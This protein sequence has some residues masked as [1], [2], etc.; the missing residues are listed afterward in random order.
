M[1]QPRDLESFTLT[2][3]DIHRAAGSV[4]EQH[5][6]LQRQYGHI[7]T[8]LEDCGPAPP[9][10]H[11]YLPVFL[12]TVRQE[13]RIA[14]HIKHLS[15]IQQLEDF[16][17]LNDEHDLSLKDALDSLNISRSEYQRDWFEG[18]ERGVKQLAAGLLLQVLPNLE[19]FHWCSGTSPLQLTT[20]LRSRLP[21]R[22]E[23]NRPR[24][25][26]LERFYKI[27]TP[28]AGLNPPLLPALKKVILDVPEVAH[29]TRGNTVLHQII[30][31]LALASIESL[32][33][34]SFN[35][36]APPDERNP[37]IALVP[38]RCS[39][40]REL[41]LSLSSLGEALD[42]LLRLPRSLRRLIFVAPVPA[43]APAPHEIFPLDRLR[44]YDLERLTI[45]MRRWHDHIDREALPRYRKLLF[46]ETSVF[47]TDNATLSPAGWIK[48]YFPTSMQHIVF[49]DEHFETQMDNFLY[50]QQILEL[51][52][53]G[54]L[55]DL[56]RLTLRA[57]RVRLQGFEMEVQ[58]VEQDC[59]AQDVE[60]NV[61]FDWE[62]SIAA[63]PT[64]DGKPVSWW[65]R[66][67]EGYST[68]EVD[69]IIGQG[70][71]YPEHWR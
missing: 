4:L 28:Q 38:H 62:R 48:H 27:Q 13:P 1:L 59:A 2:C 41:V 43:G 58:R 33:I 39:N 22:L 35:Y 16:F 45:R 36:S 26:N 40:L 42:H 51:R 56:M 15:L 21:P 12:K 29:P 60:F 46:V 55:P 47:L 7:S 18:E 71:P 23:A 19:T 5:G 9:M 25:S 70:Q 34:T 32:N 24:L 63:S 44:L 57:E 50:F 52:R 64:D 3:K 61:D 10:V 54:T 6:V 14:A 65:R 67:H 20:L 30:P 8:G 17:N 37:T 69:E 68:I 53:A 66:S 49:A 31:F 11:H